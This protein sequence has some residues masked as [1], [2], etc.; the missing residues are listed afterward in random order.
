MLKRKQILP[1]LNTYIQSF[2]HK[3]TAPVNMYVRMSLCHRVIAHALLRRHYTN[4]EP[5][6]ITC[7]YNVI[8]FSPETI[9][10]AIKDG[11]EMG[12]I[13]VVN[14][15]DKRYKKIKASKELVDTF[16]QNH[17]ESTYPKQQQN[18]RRSIWV[19]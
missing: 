6:G 19:K 9:R 13:K 16:E 7:M 18:E 8:P 10:R 2:T 17:V 3:R 14:G 12:I 4:E 5:K 15:G 11:V 1:Y